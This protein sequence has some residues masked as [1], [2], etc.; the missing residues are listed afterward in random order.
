MIQ[1]KGEKDS[2]I[3]DMFRPMWRNAVQYLLR[4]N[5]THLSRPLCGDKTKRIPKNVFHVLLSLLECNCIS[6]LDRQT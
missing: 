1:S 5:N 2:L 6:Q 4:W 3:E